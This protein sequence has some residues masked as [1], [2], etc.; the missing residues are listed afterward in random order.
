M[1][2][3]VS[4]QVCIGSLQGRL[5]VIFCVIDKSSCQDPSLRLFVTFLSPVPLLRWSLFWRRPFLLLLVDLLIFLPAWFSTFHGQI[6]LLYF[7]LSFKMVRLGFF[8]F[9]VPL[10]I[11][12]SASFLLRGSTYADVIIDPPDFQFELSQIFIEISFL[13]RSDYH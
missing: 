11:S 9:L 3:S 4:V 2:C 1:V 10:E 5:T 13:L 8:D 6:K 12:I 7:R